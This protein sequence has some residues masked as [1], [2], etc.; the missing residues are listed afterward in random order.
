MLAALEPM[1]FKLKPFP[2]REQ[3]IIVIK[4]SISVKLRLNFIIC[5]FFATF[6][7]LYDV[8]IISLF[9]SYLSIFLIK[10]SLFVVLCRT[11]SPKSNKKKSLKNDVIVAVGGDGTMA[12]VLQGIVDSGR[13]RDVR[14]GIIPLGSGNAFRKSFKIPRSLKKALRILAKGETREMDLIDIEGK[15]AGFASIGATAQVTLEKLKH[16]IHGLFG[17][18][19]ASRIML[20]LPCKEELQLSGFKSV[21]PLLFLSLFLLIPPELFAPKGFPPGIAPFVN[22]HNSDRRHVLPLFLGSES[23]EGL[24]GLLLVPVGHC[25]QV[26]SQAVVVP[27]LYR[28]F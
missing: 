14:L 18:L 28:G 11:M 9:N 10:M 15:V 4:I 3:L 13:A 26:Q 22:F 5:F 25:D 2:K 8:L 17:H 19:L 6:L 27:M 21:A 12:D 16:R 1:L 20:R 24:V 23:G 7:F